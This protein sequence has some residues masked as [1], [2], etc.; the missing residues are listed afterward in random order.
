MIK[1]LKTKWL[2]IF[3]SIYERSNSKNETFLS[4]FDIQ[5]VRL[6]VECLRP[7]LCSDL[8]NPLKSCK[9]THDAMENKYGLY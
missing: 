7:E 5:Y 9:S 3:K 6:R 1:S 4:S 8:I 2:G